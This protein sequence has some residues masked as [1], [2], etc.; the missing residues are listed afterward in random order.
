MQSNFQIS[1]LQAHT[2]LVYRCIA[3]HFKDVIASFQA[4]ANELIT[5]TLLQ[6]LSAA[7]D[8][9]TISSRGS[10]DQHNDTEMV[11]LNWMI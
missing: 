11:S 3:S 7:T 5:Y 6:L 1:I 9:F 2:Q 4:S 8:E 10:I